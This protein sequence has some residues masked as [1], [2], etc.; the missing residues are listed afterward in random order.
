MTIPRILNFLS[1]FKLPAF[2]NMVMTMPF[3]SPIGISSDRE[4]VGVPNLAAG[5]RADSAPKLCRPSNA[6]LIPACGA[7]IRNKRRRRRA[8]EDG[9]QRRPS[10][11]NL[12]HASLRQRRRHGHDGR[13][14]ALFA[15]ERVNQRV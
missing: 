7:F 4:L 10:T 9:P 12:T 8:D 6:S 15:T 5:R 2:L 14:V 11:H 3:S 1:F 13:R